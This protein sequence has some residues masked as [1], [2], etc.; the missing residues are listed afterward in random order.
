MTALNPNRRMVRTS[1]LPDPNQYV[2]AMTGRFAD[3]VF[4]E[5]EAPLQKG[6]WREALGCQP[7]TCV[8]LEIGTGNGYFFN[9]RALSQPDRTLLGMELKYKPLI[10]TIKRALHSGAQNAYVIRYHANLLK[11]LFASRELNNVFIFFPDPWPKKRH[12]KNRLVQE[13]FLSTLHE[14]QAPGSFVEIKTDNAEY[15]DWILERLPGSPY[16]VSRSTRDLHSSEWAAENFQTHFEKL[17]TSKGLKT[18]L[19]RLEHD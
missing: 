15:F 14:L 3:W 16:R 8:D 13:D 2:Q 10:Q 6:R 7:T 12:W 4:T 19:V 9:H 17:W 1:T 18:H 5:E 11:D